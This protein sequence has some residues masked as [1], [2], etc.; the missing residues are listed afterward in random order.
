MIR[1]GTIGT[2]SIVAT[3]SQACSISACAQITAVYSRSADTGRR[4]ASANA[5]AAAVYDDMAAFLAA[6][7]VDAVYIASPNSLHY[8]QAL[9]C[10]QQGKHVLCEKPATV[11]PQELEQ[12]LELARQKGLVFM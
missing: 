9:A 6:E 5:P 10:L 4:F 1:F 3:F 8:Q 7:D 2:G 11:T 12:L